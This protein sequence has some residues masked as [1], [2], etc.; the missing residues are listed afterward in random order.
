MSFSWLTVVSS[1]C[2]GWEQEDLS[3]GKEKAL[4]FSLKQGYPILISFLTVIA[5]LQEH[6]NTPL[7][8][9]HPEETDIALPNFGKKL[10]GS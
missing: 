10:N 3:V 6:C 2:G 8:S 7:S 4:P 9:H 5:L 1:L